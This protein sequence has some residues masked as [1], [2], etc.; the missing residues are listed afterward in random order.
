[1]NLLNGP[2]NNIGQGLP[3]ILAAYASMK[4][5]QTFLAMDEKRDIANHLDSNDEKEDGNMT[6]KMESASLSWLPDS[7]IVLE[8]VDIELKPGKLHMIVGP[9]ASVSSWPSRPC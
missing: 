5:I 1:M 8:D 7:P 6:V 3:S 2:L 9:V 4:R